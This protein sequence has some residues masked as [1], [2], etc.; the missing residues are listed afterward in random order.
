[1]EG[2][3]LGM[4][5]RKGA[6]DAKIGVRKGRTLRQYACDQTITSTAKNQKSKI[7]K[8]RCGFTPKFALKLTTKLTAMLAAKRLLQPPAL[9]I[10]HSPILPPSKSYP[11][12]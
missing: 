2:H 4:D 7:G 9:P 8:A 11:E 1:M 6:E 5:S 10:F 12:P 3:G